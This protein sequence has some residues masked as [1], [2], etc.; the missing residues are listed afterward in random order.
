MPPETFLPMSASAALHSERGLRR[1]H[2]PRPPESK[3]ERE[4]QRE[5]AGLVLP[6]LEVRLN[7]EGQRSG[8]AMATEFMMD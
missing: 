8:P 6:C 4:R 5:G 2:D 7:D 3:T 1:P